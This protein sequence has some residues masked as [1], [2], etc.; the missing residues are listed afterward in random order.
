MDKTIDHYPVIRQIGQGGM[1]E[2]YLVYDPATDRQLALK[3]CRE[4]K[5]HF[6]KAAHLAKQMNHPNIIPVYAIVDKPGLLYFT[7]PY[8]EG[9]SLKELL[10]HAPVPVLAKIFLKICGAVHYVHTQGFIHQD[11]KPSNIIVGTDGEPHLLDPLPS[12]GEETIS[13]TFMYLA[14]EILMGKPPSV[15]SDIY[16]LGMLLYQ[17]LTLRLPFHRENLQEYLE[18]FHREVLVDPAIASPSRSIPP[19][20]SKMALKCLTVNPEERYRTVAEMIEELTRPDIYF[21]PDEEIVD[22]P[23]ALQKRADAIRKAFLSANPNALAALI[24][25]MADSR[26]APLSLIVMA[27]MGLLELGALET[28]AIKLG[29]L[30]RYHLDIQALA[31]LKWVEAAAAAKEK[32]TIAIPFL[33]EL[34]K[35]I[36]PKVLWPVLFLL[37]E[38][39]KRRQTALVHAVL[40]QL[41]QHDIST[42]QQ[43]ELDRIWIWAY[44]WDLNWQSAEAILREYPEEVR[45]SPSFHFLYHLFQKKAPKA[46]S[47][48][49]PWEKQQYQE[50]LALYQKIVES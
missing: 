35:K 42:A 27:L 20:L 4:D 1:G 38:A 6:L 29:E 47:N 39:L 13:G 12:K 28:A 44:L 34:P 7:M 30:F 11:L 26:P 19:A 24:D 16:S 33:A 31:L 18:N 32:E 49:S 2:V 36:D 15:Q 41:M 14:P 5:G 43:I 3:L 9:E 37:K 25:Q 48:P 17:M 40:P 10:T 45:E 50:D 46:P 8:I 21:I 22:L 23:D